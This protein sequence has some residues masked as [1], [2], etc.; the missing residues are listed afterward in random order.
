MVGQPV[1][2]PLAEYIIRLDQKFP[3]CSIIVICDCPADN[4]YIRIAPHFILN[5]QYNA[6]NQYTQRHD[7]IMF[8]EKQTGW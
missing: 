6:S 7:S 2:D 5:E 1:S 3:D 4:L 8:S